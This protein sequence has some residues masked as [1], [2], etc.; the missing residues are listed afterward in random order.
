MPPLADPHYIRRSEAAAAEFAERGVRI[1][2]VRLATTVHGIG[3]PAFMAMLARLARETGVSAYLGDGAGRWPAVHVSDAGQ[4]YRLALGAGAPARAY[5]A[6][7]EEGSPSA[8]SRRRSAARSIYRSS[9]DPASIS[10]GSPGSSGPTHPSR[11]PARANSPA[12][13][14]PARPCSPTWPSRATSLDELACPEAE[15]SRTPPATIPQ[16]AGRG[17]NEQHEWT[18]AYR[19]LSRQPVRAQSGALLSDRFGWSRQFACLVSHQGP[20]GAP[21]APPRRSSLTGC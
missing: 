8:R 12:G 19:K 16:A 4:L 1:G 20:S 9:L 13:N 11:A 3:D 14:L 17:G 10:A 5:H 6:C 15:P 2:A 21:T 18:A 7:A